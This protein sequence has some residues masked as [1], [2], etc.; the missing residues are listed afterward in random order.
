MDAWL[1]FAITATAVVAGGTVLART[2]DI[3]ATETGIGRLWMGSVL[4]AVTTSAP[5]LVTDVSAVRQGALDLAIGDLFGSSMANM[6]ILGAIG[7]AFPTKRLLQSVALENVLT[8]TLAILLT[9][10]AVLFLTAKSQ[11]GVG[12]VGLGPVLIA[13]GWLA[14]VAALREV[15]G[16]AGSHGEPS[17]AGTLRRAVAGFAAAALLIFA[18][19]PFLARTAS[20]L[21][22]DTGVGETFF[23]TLALALVT[24]LPELVVSA[25]AVRLGALDL[26]LGNLFGSNA[27]NMAILLVLELAHTEGRIMEAADLSAATPAVVAIGLMTIGIAAIVLKAERRRL[28]FDLSAAALV[29]GYLMGALAVYD[30]SA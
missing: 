29:A 30:A 15:H 14:G 11:P 2:A 21:A 27:E 17:G 12:P 4:V 20:E 19:G 28:P 10:L 26:A 9:V 23:G 18:A 24:S 7:L 6:A 16:R 22:Q 13:A 5:E 3:I 8:A 1:L 25:T